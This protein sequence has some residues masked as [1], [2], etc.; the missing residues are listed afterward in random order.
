MF[1]FKFLGNTRVPHH[2]N[3]AD[4]SPIKMPPPKDIFLPMSQHIGAP[5]TPVVKVG[6]EVKVGQLVAE[7]TGYVS[8]P[9]HSPVSGK[10]V[11][12]DSSLFSNGQVYPA[13]QIENDGLMTLSEEVAPPVI[14]D[15]ESLIAAVRASGLV[16]LGGAGFPTSVKFDALKKGNI[17]TVIINAAE[18]EPYITSDTRT[19]LDH[20]DL[21]YAGVELLK[22]HVASVQN[23][24]LGIEKNKPTCIAKMKEIFR[25]DPTV[26]IMP[27]PSLYPQGSEK[28]IIYNT[29]KQVVPQ[30]KL[31]ADL[32]MMVMNVTSLAF[33]ASYVQTGM[34]LIEK[35]VTVDGGAVKEPK[36]LLIPIG[37]TIR[38][39]LDFAGVAMEDVGK[40]LFGGPMM[41]IAA[42]SLEETVGK[43]TNALTVMTEA[44]SVELETT[45]CIHCGKCVNACPMHLDPSEFSNAYELDTAEKM[46]K[47]DHYVVQLCMECG[48]CAY[49]C[50]AN[51]PLVQNNRLAKIALRDYKAHQSTLK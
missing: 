44:E 32:G 39:V 42:S 20:A 23:I 28:V 25:D 7:A 51:R 11:K 49:V 16:G 37:T 12:I 35:C 41:G 6:D 34:P 26:S 5:A 45:A 47:F 29:T 33:L 27:L 17:H 19:M 4:M 9:I 31:P 13:L 21:V 18:C 50:P 36:N 24:I 43:R 48:S 40:V 30:G 15:L 3:T 22:K 10:V 14:T 46:A 1:G 8:A 38:D 2:K